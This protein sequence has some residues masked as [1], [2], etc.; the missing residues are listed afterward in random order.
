M[1]SEPRC[2]LSVIDFLLGGKA[3][4]NR[5]RLVQLTELAYHGL[6]IHIHLRVI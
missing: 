6:D 2:P 5:D 3:K 1:E 4:G